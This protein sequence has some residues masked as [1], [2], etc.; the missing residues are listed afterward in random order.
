MQDDFLDSETR[1]LSHSEW[2]GSESRLQRQP[3][4][5]IPPDWLVSLNPASSTLWSSHVY[6]SPFIVR[7]RSLRWTSISLLSF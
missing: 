7:L 5:G 3:K 6:L 4:T 1:R 2:R